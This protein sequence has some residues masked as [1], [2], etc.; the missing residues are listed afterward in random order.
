MV[1][2]PLCMVFDLDVVSHTSNAS[3]RWLLGNCCFELV[4][5]DVTSFPAVCYAESVVL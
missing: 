4:E 1:T 2:G 5:T 3:F